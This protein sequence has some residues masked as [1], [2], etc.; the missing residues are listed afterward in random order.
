MEG[1]VPLQTVDTA[2]LAK[3]ARQSLN[4]KPILLA[5]DVADVSPSSNISP[6]QLIPTG[7]TAAAKTATSTGIAENAL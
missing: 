5:S 2:A 7:V 1:L 3:T 4:F 6:D